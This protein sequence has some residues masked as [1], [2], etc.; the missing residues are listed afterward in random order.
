MLHLK[1][2][3][4]VAFGT[5]KLEKQTKIATHMNLWKY[6]QILTIQKSQVIKWSRFSKKIFFTWIYHIVLH[7]IL[8]SNNKIGMWI[9]INFSS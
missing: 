5:K 2:S 4:K 9:N 7:Y 6:G 1:F 8:N 3:K